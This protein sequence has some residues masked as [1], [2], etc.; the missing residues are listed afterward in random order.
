MLLSRQPEFSQLFQEFRDVFATAP[1]GQEHVTFYARHRQ[2]GR[3]NFAEIQ[4]AFQRLNI[5]EPDQVPDGLASQLLQKLLP[6]S[7]SQTHRDDGFWIHHAP[8]ITGDIQKWYEADGSDWDWKGIAYG[9][10]Q[11]LTAC[12]ADP[13]QLQKY[14]DEFLALDCTRGLQSGMLTPILNALNPDAFLLVNGKSQNAIAYFT[15]GKCSSQLS[16]YPEVNRRGHELIAQLTPSMEK[17]WP[18]PLSPADQFDMFC[19][20]LVSLKKHSLKPA[21]YWKIAPGEGGK[22]W[23]EWREQGFISIGWDE[24]G[25]ISGLD[26]KQFQARRD[27]LTCDNPERKAT[28]LNQVWA[29]SQMKPGD[30]IAANRGT[31]EVLGIGTV[32]GPYYYQADAD[33]YRHRL[34]VQWDE[35]LPRQVNQPGWR[36][37][38]IGLNDKIWKSIL[39]APER[40]LSKV[41]EAMTSQWSESGTAVNPDCP[42][43]PKTFELLELL[44]ATPRKEFYDAHKDEFERQLKRPFQQLM[45]TVAAQLPEPIREVMETQKRLFGQIHK[46]DYG[47]GNTYDYYWGAFY[48]KGG[49]RKTSAQLSMWM[50]H[51]R[52]EFGF[53]IGDY[54]DEQRERFQRNCDRLRQ[55][56]VSLLKST[57]DCDRFYFGPRDQLEFDSQGNIL[58]RKKL[59]FADWLSHPDIFQTDLGHMGM[60]LSK[61]QILQQSEQALAEQMLQT[62][63]QLFPLVLLAIHDEPIPFIRDYLESEDA[64]EEEIAPPLNEAYPLS[65]CAAET[66]LDETQLQTWIQALNRKGQAVL[67]GPPGTGKTF[68]AHKLSQHLLSEGDGFWELVQFHPAYSYEDFIQGIRP[69]QGLN[70]LDYP[71]VPG[72][73]LEFCRKARDCKE[74]CV[75][76]I[77]ELNR[78]N[79]AQVFGELMYLLEYRQAKV[80]LASG[81]AFAIPSNV[82]IIG[83]MNTADRSIALVDHALRRRFAFLPLY[84]QYSGLEQFHQQT[85]FAA[86]G[87]VQTLKTINQAIGDRQYALGTSFFLRDNLA[88]EL[89]SIWQLEIEPYLEEYFFDRSDQVESF[90]WEVLQTQLLP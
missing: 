10:Y 67:Y 73:F 52:L 50:N 40:P 16:D 85:G 13:A 68:L 32:T 18:S 22:Y 71:V 80:S 2:S 64:D 30:R 6:H 37:T 4:A 69:K 75:L 79:L 5:T 46:N 77:D 3:E 31:T 88:V 7:D 76:I 41:R 43:S 20:W 78:A 38:L 66:Y 87:L 35:Q 15:D 27:Q 62:Y 51:E 28:G 39:E 11:W 86:A 82:R 26:K 58:N 61:P 34:P 25:D 74:T 1:E 60:V 70:G 90:R 8:A 53:Y 17:I 45:Q 47:Q 42:F 89:K 57:L 48:A 49:K 54:G 84:P 24:L 44:H 36:K 9:I 63:A 33:H 56:L 65:Q 29:F 72:R 19:H 14:C 23:S 21:R 12:L 55:D 59:P 81:Q 83:T